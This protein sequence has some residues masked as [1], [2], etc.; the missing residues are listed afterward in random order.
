MIR[1]FVVLLTFAFACILAIAQ[2]RVVVKDSE[3]TLDTQWNGKHV[4]YLGDSMTDPNTSVTT[5]WYWQYLKELLNI[6]Y[7]V[8][9]VSG[10][11][12]SD[13]YRM[14]EKVY[15]EKKDSIHAVFIWAGTN[16][17]NNNL[18]IGDFFTEEIKQTNHNGKFVNRKHRT[19]IL[20]D[21]TFC[22]RINK[23]LSFLKEHYPTKQIVILTPIHRGY[24]KFGAQNIQ[25]SEDFANGQGLYLDAYI[26]AL[27]KAGS[28]WSVPVI[29]LYSISGLYPVAD[30]FTPYF[31]NEK[32]DR[33]HPN[34][35]GHYRLAKT[36]QY[37]LLTLPSEY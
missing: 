14:A 16:D 15:A 24:A 4:A 25:P 1:R 26:D 5:Y 20:S 31:T 33:L 7:S 29:D 36:I 17:Y 21:S 35:K 23:V 22:G 32:T 37:Q 8:Y 2:D 27:K 28:Y 13:I 10:Y 19:F 12:W 9:A 34:A 3:K 30:S 6:D 11:Q 18:P